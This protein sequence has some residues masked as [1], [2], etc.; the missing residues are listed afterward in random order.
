MITYG[1]HG[2]VECVICALSNVYDCRWADLKR[3]HESRRDKNGIALPSEYTKDE[4]MV[5]VKYSEQAGKWG[6]KKGQSAESG[7]N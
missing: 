5:Y 7:M 2:F 6:T 4:W 3:N 1:S